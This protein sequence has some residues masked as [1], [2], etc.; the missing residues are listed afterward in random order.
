MLKMDINMLSF[1]KNYYVEND[2]MKHTYVECK[3]DTIIDFSHIL[4]K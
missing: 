2:Y 3:V 1:V 4:C